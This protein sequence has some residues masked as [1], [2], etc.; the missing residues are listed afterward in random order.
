MLSYLTLTL[1]L[2]ATP[3]DDNLAFQEGKRLSEQFEYEKAVFRFREAA[4][5]ESLGVE[6]ATALVWLGLTYAKIGE[7]GAADEAFLQAVRLDPLVA[8]PPSTPPKI[9]EAL[10][11]A[12]RRLRDSSALERPVTTPQIT[13]TRTID[14]SAAC[15]HGLREGDQCVDGE[16]TTTTT[17][18][19][20]DTRDPAILVTGGILLGVG[21]VV[22]GGAVYFG[23]TASQTATSAAA[24][25]FQDERAQLNND[26]GSQALIANVL[27]GVGA[28][29]AVGGL[30]TLGV[31]LAGG[32][33]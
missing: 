16:A 19:G 7:Q 18:T 5:D 17:D 15:K 31:G 27:Y 9:L 14:P 12:R 21:A 10:E 20:D 1:L 29:V 13:T 6:R 32:G 8:L 22:V 30:A 24:A 4:R 26:A 11:G 25:V 2:Q 28:A 3:L 23:L 33:Q